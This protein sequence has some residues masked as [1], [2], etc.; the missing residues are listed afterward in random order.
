RT[1]M[2]DYSRWR[3]EHGG[4]DMVYSP[5]IAK[6][7]LWETSGH[8]DFYAD[9]MYPPMEMDGAT[10]YPKPMNCPFHV[11][12]YRSSLRSYRDLPL[13]YFELGTVYRYELSGAVHGLMRS[14]GFTQ[15]DAHIFT[16]RDDIG[17]ELASLL[18]FVLSVLR[19]FGFDDFQAKLSTRPAEKAVGDDEIWDMATEGLRQALEKAGLEY[20][21][22]E[23]GGA[24]YG[25]KIDVDVRD[26]IG[27][28]WQLSTIQLDFNLPER[29][30][31]EYVGA[32]GQRHQPVM[33]HRALMGSL[34]RF[35]G[36]L[37]EHYAGAFPAWLAPV[38]VR[39]LPVADEHEDHVDGLAAQLRS[40][41]FRVDVARASEPLG[42]RV[43]NGK[44]EKIPYLLVVGDDD[45]ANGTVGVNQ[46]G[47]SDPDRDVTVDDFIKRLTIEIDAKSANG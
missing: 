11:M 24:F 28:A 4:Y 43:R 2:E 41:G 1:A 19:A 10:Y 22:D 42:K 13:R 7:V 21:V 5:H 6:S 31:L 40:E 35:F 47:Q 16:T 39:L 27:R 33:I 44:V 36:V 46:R 9:G 14:R 25:P 32:D 45:L 12:I 30:G 29:F 37:I 18:D 26:A 34:E 15:D 3:H 38:Q 23:G 17:S 20:V 8:L